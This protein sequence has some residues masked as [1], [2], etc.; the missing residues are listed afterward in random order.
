MAWSATC[1]GALL[2]TKLSL[3]L[4]HMVFTYLPISSVPLKDISMNFVLGLLRTNRGMDSI[5]VVV[6]HFSKMAH[7]YL[8]TRAIMHHML[9]ICSSLKLFIYVVFQILLSQIEILNS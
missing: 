4:T 8:V 9:M 5:F 7:L 2:A 1:H 6:D 3:N